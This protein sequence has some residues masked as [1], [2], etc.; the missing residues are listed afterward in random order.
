MLQN[1][2]SL[3]VHHTAHNIEKENV[4]LGKLA[5]ILLQFDSTNKK[6]YHNDTKVQ[7]TSS[8]SLGS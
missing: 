6:I 4:W 2:S 5:Y 7:E 3:P 1:R 8:I